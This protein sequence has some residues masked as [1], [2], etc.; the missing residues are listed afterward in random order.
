MSKI[1]LREE[2]YFDDLEE[3]LGY[4]L[5]IDIENTICILLSY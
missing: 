5:T 3:D 2:Q 1:Y 4:N